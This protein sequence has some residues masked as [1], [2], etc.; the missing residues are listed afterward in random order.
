VALRPRLSSGLP[1]SL[2]LGSSYNAPSVR[3]QTAPLMNVRPWRSA[4]YA[5]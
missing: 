5:A 3:R 1:L 2:V 4:A